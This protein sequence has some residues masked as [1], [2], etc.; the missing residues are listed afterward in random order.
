MHLYNSPRRSE[1]QAALYAKAV[2]RWIDGCAPEV[3]LHLHFNRTS[4]WQG[5]KAAL[6]HFSA[7]V[8]RDALGPGWRK[9]FERRLFYIS[10]L[11]HRQS[12]AHWHAAGRLPTPW[13]NRCLA[14]VAAELG[15]VWEN[16]VP[17]GSVYL[18]KYS[19]VGFAEYMTK[20]FWQHDGGENFVISTEFAPF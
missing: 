3:C 6:K 15:H 7:V 5:A 4:T 16:V 14:D 17:S 2:A 8:D 1:E 11:E 20:E 10:V 19:N 18:N 12:N 9:K 13:K